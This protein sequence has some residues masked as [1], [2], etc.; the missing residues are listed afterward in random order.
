[1]RKAICSLLFLNFAARV[2]GATLQIPG[3]TGSL[4]IDGVV[5]EAIWKQATV[6]PA[7]SP[8]FGASFPGRGEMRAVVRGSFLCLS[9]R[10]PETS[11]VV[12]RSTGINPVSERLGG[13]Y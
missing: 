4:T 3:A 9:A 2:S 7:H 12:A 8:G 5:D 11:R 1:M 13:G 10:M 6:L